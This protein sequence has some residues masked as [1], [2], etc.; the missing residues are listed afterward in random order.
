MLNFLQLVENHILMKKSIYFLLCFSL[1][2]SCKEK[3]EIAPVP[4]KP[5]NTEPFVGRW[6]YNST[7]YFQ[8]PTTVELSEFEIEFLKDFTFVH[9]QNKKEIRRGK[10]EFVVEY[11]PYFIE[12][13]INLPRMKYLDTGEKFYYFYAYEKKRYELYIFFNSKSIE[14]T[15]EAPYH[16]F[17]LLNK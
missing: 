10:Y 9:Y 11:N 4:I 6:I 15:I 1:L 16:I 7:H 5:I 14:E 13:N 3:E 8:N 2:L 17:I 12:R